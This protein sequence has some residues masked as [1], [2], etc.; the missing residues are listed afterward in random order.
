[1]KI[2]KKALKKLIFEELQKEAVKVSDLQRQYEKERSSKSPKILDLM[3]EVASLGHEG[4]ISFLNV[5]D[6]H[7][8]NIKITAKDL[9][10]ISENET[11]GKV[12]VASKDGVEMMRSNIFETEEELIQLEALASTLEAQ[13]FDV[14]V[15][16]A[17]AQDKRAVSIEDNPELKTY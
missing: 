13:G 17:G 6:T 11:F 10:G 8:K 9:V 14:E 4:V 3:R 15:V 5:L 2:T 7:L 1:V 16:P 12:L